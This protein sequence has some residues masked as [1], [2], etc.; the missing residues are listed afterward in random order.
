MATP[1]PNQAPKSKRDTMLERMQNKYPD[2][3]FNDEEAL[4]GR[5]SDDYDAYDQELAGYKDREGK[6]SD[7]FTSDPRSARIMMGWKDGEDPAVNLVR[8]YGT[9]IA[10]AI[11]DPERQEAIAEANREYMERV[12]KEKEY[13]DQYSANLAE[14]LSTL[15]KI[16]Q[17]RGLTDDQI[18]GAMS[19]LIS[20]S[21]DAM[22]GK[23]TPET[24]EMAIKAQ[25]Y[26]NAVEQAGSEGE[27]RGKNTKIEEKLRKPSRGD[28]TPAL[29]G[30]NGGGNSRRMPDLGVIDQIGGDGTKNIYER[31]GE[32][33]TPIKR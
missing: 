3:D 10:D 17:E 5:I 12:T 23:F 31:G 21:K 8:L 1:D 33:R 26:D 4:Y 16:Q 28:G 27:L 14:S 22:L 9:E 18:D 24:I 30:K 6:F 13:E 19:W 7:M 20:I 32:K 2:M 15:E 29:D 11:D 25:N